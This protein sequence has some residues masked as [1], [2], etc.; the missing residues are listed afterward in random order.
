M[1][2]NYDI[3]DDDIGLGEEDK[4]KVQSNQV[5]W[6]KGVAKKTD[7]V[8]LMYFNPLEVSA[9]KK[10]LK[11]KSDLSDAQ[12]AEIAEKVKASQAQKLGKTVDQLDQVDMLD[13]SEAR[14]KKV[15]AHYKEGVGFV[16]SRLGKDG[17]EADKV[18]AT[19]PEPKTYV[20]TLLLIYP[21]DEEGELDK[22]KLAKGWV[23]KPW[24]MPPDKYE[25]LRKINRGLMNSGSSI[26][27]QDLYLSCT[28]A[29][30]QKI[31]ITQAGPAIWLRNDSFRR[32]VLSK[33]VTMYGKLNPSRE[34]TTDELRE[35]LG[36]GGGESGGSSGSGGVDLSG[37]DFSAILSNV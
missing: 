7:L 36:M 12:K 4:G 37:E 35:K 1:S 28:D 24:R 9:I 29:K 3:D 15:V 33:A 8:A 31:D 11:Q 23:L 21:T 10:A 13:L 19:L 18:W 14:F 20:T 30:F 5:D 16:T 2:A 17:P 25:K 27:V 34:I 22:S 26:A 6:Y 32:L